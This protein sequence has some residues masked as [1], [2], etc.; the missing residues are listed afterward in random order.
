[1]TDDHPAKMAEERINVGYHKFA[2]PLHEPARTEMMQDVENQMEEEAFAKKWREYSKGGLINVAVVGYQ[3]FIVPLH[4]P[5]RTEMQ[6]D[7]AHGM[8][9]KTFHE[10]WDKY[11]KVVPSKWSGSG[12]LDSLD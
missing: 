10:K 6:L 12:D 7:F 11:K 9:V 4:E 8:D 1:M 5:D 2:V 3:A